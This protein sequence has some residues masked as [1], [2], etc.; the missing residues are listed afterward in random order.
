MSVPGS[1]LTDWRDKV[2]TILSMM[3]PGEQMGNAIADIVFGAVAPQ[4]KLPI[5]FPNKENEQGL[6]TEQYPGV[7][8]AKFNL[9]ATYSEGQIVGYRW[10]DKNKVKPA[11]GF[12]HGLSYGKFAYSDLKVAGNTI[13]FTAK[14]TSG[15]D[16]SCD[17]PQIYFG[18]PDAATNA[19]V[20]VKVMRYFKKTCD[21]EATISYDYTNRDVSNW[22][23]SSKAFKVTKGTYTVYVGSSSQEADLTTTF[24][25]S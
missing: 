22:D 25:V 15:S 1:I 7:K 20:P 12:G 24:T 5:T 19:K 2:P 21:A 14:R 10:Y 13:S 11:F 17:T 18:Y 8:T 9:Q 16:S 3:L 23:T 4:A 6:T